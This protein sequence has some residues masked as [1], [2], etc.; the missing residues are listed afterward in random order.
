M[1]V[2]KTMKEAPPKKKTKT[3]VRRRRDGDH[4]DEGTPE[5]Q[6]STTGTAA[7]AA[8]PTTA[9]KRRKLDHGPADER[10]G[11]PVPK[12]RQGEQGAGKGDDDGADE[13]NMQQKI[14]LDTNMEKMKKVQASMIC[15][16]TVVKKYLR[17]VAIQAVPEGPGRL[18]IFHLLEQRKIQKRKEK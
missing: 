9:T 13:K 15:V 11:G 10:G 3:K 2:D 16:A 17:V 4:P 5:K 12:K 6:P 14:K 18:F 1:G 7:T 8:T